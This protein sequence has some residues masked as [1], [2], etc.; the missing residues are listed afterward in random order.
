MVYI[1][2]RPGSWV[3]DVLNT[4]VPRPGWIA[5]TS[6]LQENV[7]QSWTLKWVIFQAT[8]KQTQWYYSIYSIY[9]SSNMCKAQ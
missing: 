3:V 5:G 1:K 7:G 2:Q 4:D 9:Y 8:E 6:H